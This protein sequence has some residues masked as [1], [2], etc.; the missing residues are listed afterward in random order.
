M[1][2]Y[3]NVTAGLLYVETAAPLDSYR[4]SD[5]NGNE[6]NCPKLRCKQKDGG[7]VTTL[8]ASELEAWSVNTPVLY[9]LEAEGETVRFGH[10][11]IR[12][13]QN[14][15]ILLNEKPVYLRG[16]I[17]GIVAYEHPNMTGG[18]DYEAACK[19]IRQAKKYGFNIV[20]FHSTIPS[21]DFLCAADELGML[22][23]LETGFKYKWLYNEQNRPMK[24]VVESFG[25]TLWEDTILRLRNHPSIAVF[26]IGNEMH[27]SSHYP[28]VHAMIKKGRELAPAKLIMDN[29]GWGEYD[30][31][32]AD[33]YIQHMGYYLPYAH[34]NDMFT[35]DALW[36]LDASAYDVPLR[37]AS[38]EGTEGPEIIR[39]C[40]PLKPVLAHE[41]MHYIDI[42]DYAALEKKFDEFC[43]R[44]GP[45]YLERHEIKK[46]KYFAGIQKLIEQRGL[47]EDMPDYMAATRKM[48]LICTKLYIERLRLSNKLCGYEMLQFSDCLKYE[49]KNGIVDFFDDDKGIDYKWMLEMNDD[50][51]LLADFAQDRQYEDEEVRVE[52]YASDFLPEF[53]VNGTLEVA[54]DG[55]VIYLGEQFALAG[56]LQKLLELKTKVKAAGKPQ[57]HVLAARFISGDLEVKNS[58][59]F[60]TY[61]R[62][63]P[64]CVPEMDLSNEVLANYLR[65]GSKQSDLYVTD[66]FNQKVFDK[67]DAGKTVVLLYEYLA[68][69]NTWDVQGAM[70][71]FKPCIWDRGHGLGGILPNKA[72][73]EVLG[74]DKYFDRNVQP[75]L[76]VGSKVNLDN[77]P[78]KVTEHVMGVDKPVRDRYRASRDGV[79]DFVPE[80]TLRR[81]SHLFSVMVGNG[82]LVVCTFNLKDPENPVVS[83]FLELLMDRT[84]VLGAETAI[85]AE[86]FKAWLDKINAAGFREEDTM[87]RSWQ[88][89][90]EPVEKVLFWEDLNLN[91]AALK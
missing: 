27:R 85:S 9:T 71:R 60:W 38:R 53:R 76:D 43:Q 61:P 34:H 30:R 52:I 68:E 39:Y 59:K 69:R 42:P 90:A 26:C 12:T 20:R 48:K 70:E 35:T 77:W 91:L 7:Y 86:E 55:K 66:A 2:I 15:M 33:M 19:N 6:V 17:R 18:S 32:S 11:Q 75:L 54:L 47:A 24:K 37:I 89:D 31:D 65:K 4:I 67:L 5:V 51:V 13:L 50:L 84:D 45:E 63:R 72:V 8:D 22:V 88:N 21:D 40:D 3:S 83:N 23:H 29:C 25:E 14:K 36:K 74:D 10:T 73:E 78:C 28:E 62:V 81:F 49:N 46:P 56:G 80:D 41:S 79:K 64:M 87:N 1:Y 58:W 44:V 82:K 57:S 16:Y